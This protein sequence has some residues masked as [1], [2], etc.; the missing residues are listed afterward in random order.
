MIPFFALLCGKVL[1]AQGWE[2]CPKNCQCPQ[3][4]VVQCNKVYIRN[5][6]TG[7]MELLDKLPPDIPP[8]TTHLVL[9]ENNL[10]RITDQ[11]FENL[12][13]LIYLN[14]GENNIYKV[15]PAAFDPLVNL[16]VLWLDKNLLRSLPDDVFY[17]NQDTIEQINLES[18][19]LEFVQKYLFA[20]LE[21]LKQVFLQNNKLNFVHP[22]AFHSNTKLTRLFLHENRLTTINKDWFTTLDDLVELYLDENEFEC[23]CVMQEFLDWAKETPRMTK[24]FDAM[25]DTSPRCK[26]QNFPGR[27]L[28]KLTREEL[29]QTC[30]QP[31][32]PTS[33]KLEN[34]FVRSEE[35]LNL[36]CSASGIPPPDITWFG[37][38]NKELADK[39]SN[40]KFELD[41]PKMHAEDFGVYRCVAENLRGKDSFEVNVQQK[42]SSY[43]HHR[44]SYEGGEEYTDFSEESHIDPPAISA[45][46]EDEDNYNYEMEDE[47]CPDECFCDDHSA[48]CRDADLEE[49]PDI[50][51]LMEPTQKFD[52]RS[53]EIKEIDADSFKGIVTLKELYLDHNTIND[54]IDVNAFSEL[55]ELEYLSMVNIGLVNIQSKFRTLNTLKKLI[56]TSNFIQKLERVNFNDLTSLE[57]LYL[58]NNQISH[59]DEETFYSLHNLQYLHLQNN[60]IHNIRGE[61]FTSFTENIFVRMNLGGNE[62]DCACSSVESFVAA[63]EDKRWILSNEGYAVDLEGERCANDRSLMMIDTLLK[64]EE[65]K[66]CDSYPITESKRMPNR[67]ETKSD[68]DYME[69]FLLSDKFEFD[70]AMAG[71]H[72]AENEDGF[73]ESHEMPELPEDLRNVIDLEQFQNFIKQQPLE[74]TLEDERKEEDAFSEYNMENYADEGAPE[75]EYLKPA[76]SSD[77]PVVKAE[78]K[79]SK[80]NT[81]WVVLFFLFFAISFLVFTFKRWRRIL[82]GWLLKCGENGHGQFHG[83]SYQSMYQSNRYYNNH[84]SSRETLI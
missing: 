39:S 3:R 78:Q 47:N 32:I 66:S 36:R 75:E 4:E 42:S 53:N 76:L 9:R 34:Y 52:L 13:N 64:L 30:T 15:S 58:D 77:T 79:R 10:T 56:L 33:L 29:E 25:T 60:K 65:T 14:L 20:D 26:G 28:I 74:D 41:I 63:M 69:K 37:P 31:I 21:E 5:E 61:W 83:Q 17:E 54:K 45:V 62:I 59:I 49:V 38:D 24:L 50:S 22:K 80:S 7:K 57:R 35:P 23:N 40:Q 46:D 8:E 73:D 55:P 2:K 68:D 44:D 71:R 27:E 81:H 18:N 82:L 6:E 48:D 70:E 11:T 67:L 84:G 72:Q 16:K 19:Q 43:D 51:L 1:L 12:E